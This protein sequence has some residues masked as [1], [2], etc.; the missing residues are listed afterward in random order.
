MLV[1]LQNALHAAVFEN[2]LLFTEL[3]LEYGADVNM[4]DAGGHTAVDL[5]I[6][7]K[8]NDC[9]LVIN[10]KLGVFTFYIN[11][12]YLF[13]GLFTLNNVLFHRICFLYLFIT[14]LCL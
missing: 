5:A 8:C 3:L 9:V 6:K 10:N 2:K 11:I 13:L 1:I 12:F 4:L 14:R 7:N